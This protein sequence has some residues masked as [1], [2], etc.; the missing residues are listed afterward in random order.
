[1]PPKGLPETPRAQ[2]LCD[3]STEQ[4]GPRGTAGF[5][6]GSRGHWSSHSQFLM[7]LDLACPR[8]LI[9]MALTSH[10]WMAWPAGTSSGLGSQPMCTACL[11][12]EQGCEDGEPWP[13]VRQLH[14]SLGM[15]T[16]LCPPLTKPPPAVPGLP[17]SWP[18]SHTHGKH[19]H[20]HHGDRQALP[21]HHTDTLQGDAY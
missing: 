4:P 15:R 18:Q 8:M 17:P 6:P 10:M 12:P 3:S 7:S 9:S 13:D 5:S 1:M 20:S 14:D 16:Q 2:T 21:A 19:R 11:N